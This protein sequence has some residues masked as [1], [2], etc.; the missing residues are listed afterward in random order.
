MNLCSHLLKRAMAKQVKPPSFLSFVPWCSGN[1]CVVCCRRQGAQLHHGGGHTPVMLPRP[2]HS[3][4]KSSVQSHSN[5]RPE[6]CENFPPSHCHT[7]G[8]SS[9][10]QPPTPPL[11]LRPAPHPPPPT[12]VKPDGVHRG[13]VGD[14]VKR[15]EQRGYKLVGIKVGWGGGWGGL[16]CCVQ[17]NQL[18][19]DVRCLLSSF[20]LQQSFAL[21]CALLHEAK[22]QRCTSPLSL[23]PIPAPQVLVPSR[24]LAASHYA[25]HDGK[26]RAVGQP[27]AVCR[28]V[29]TQHARLAG[30]HPLKSRPLLPSAKLS[31][32]LLRALRAAA[33]LP[34]AGGLPQL[35]RGGEWPGGAAEQPPASAGSQPLIMFSPSPAAR[36][37][38]SARPPMDPP[39]CSLPRWPWCLRARTW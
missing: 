2:E 6:L 11:L 39:P 22:F 31:A 3:T 8:P 21:C 33:L 5:N 26:V 28:P 7:A 19:G 32:T 24:E 36:Q 17:E 23:N 9:R 34:Q 13:L 25:E 12:Q 35:G 14:I 18:Q 30:G 20:A 4:A 1:D 16:P 38:R 10:P 27:S 15:F 37:Q 29:C